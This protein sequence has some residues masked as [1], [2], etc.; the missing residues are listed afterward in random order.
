ISDLNSVSYTLNYELKRLRESI[1]NNFSFDIDKV[2]KVFEETSIYFPD[3]LKSDY[4][5]LMTFNRKLTTERNKLLKATIKQKEKELSEINSKLAQLNTNRESLL[6]HLTDSDT[7]TQFK[8]YQ[9]DLVKLE[10]Q[11]LKFQEKINTIDIIIEKE[12]RI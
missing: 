5:G 4:E 7:F 6:M 10:G 2:K 1:K 12:N 3:N 11:L 9:K 8:K